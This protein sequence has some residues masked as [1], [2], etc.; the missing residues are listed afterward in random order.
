[1]SNRNRGALIEAVETAKAHI[2]RGND[3]YESGKFKEAVAEY[4]MAVELEAEIAPHFWGGNPYAAVY[5]NRGAANSEIGCHD[6]AVDDLSKAIE[7]S[8]DEAAFYCN[9]G[10]AYDDIEQY[11]KAISDYSKAID[12]EPESPV[13]YI[14]RGRAYD[15]ID[16]KVRAVRDFDRA[17]QLD[18]NDYPAYFG[19][20]MA[21]LDLRELDRA[22][23]DINKAL[24]FNPR[25][26][27]AETVHYLVRAEA[28]FKQRKF[29]KAFA[30]LWIA[31]ARLPLSLFQRESDQ[32]AAF[33]SE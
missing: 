24:E 3:C 27:G 8:P 13:Y 15:M 1:M 29:F 17:I 23:E 7:M 22:V 14:N 12:L 25:G 28:R 21:H 10:A 26:P 4:N 9:R 11:D 32:N 16:S 30:D 6:K 33:G 19:R 5:N 18:P 20:A 2:R 31:L